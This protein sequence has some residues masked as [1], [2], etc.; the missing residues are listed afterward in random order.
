MKHS[1][2]EKGQALIL[3]VFAIFGLIGLTGLTIDGGNVYSDRRHA[4]NAA[5]AAVMAA[6]LAKVRGGD[7]EAAGLERAADN[8]YDNNGTSNT[9][10]VVSPPVSGTYVGNPDY[11]QVLIVSHVDTYFARVVGIPQMTN[12]VQA[13]SKTKLSEIGPLFD[14]QALVALKQTGTTFTTCGNPNVNVDASGI[15]VNSSSGCA[16]EV[17]G[18]VDLTVDT[19]YAIVNNTSPVCTNGNVNMVG[20]V[21]G[22][23]DQIEYPPRIDIAAPS[24]ECNGDGYL[25][26]NTYQPGNYNSITIN[27]GTINFAPGNYCFNGNV[28]INGGDVTANFVSFRLD[29]GEFLVRGNA[30]FT[31]DH[32]IVYGTGDSDGMHFNGTGDITATNTTFY[33]ETGDV[34]WNGN[35]DNT[36]TAPDTGPNANMLL[37]MPYGNTSGLTVNGNADSTIT[38]TILA[39]S[40]H[41]QVNGNS[42][43][44]ALYSQIVGYTVEACG[45]G[46]LNIHFDP[47]DNF[48]QLEPA[49]IELT[50]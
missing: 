46:D 2:Y 31:A 24:I 5:D 33:M 35:A 36:F 34:E 21:S 12:Q 37:Y 3:I 40:S 11:I 4:Q 39:V 16:M 17:I 48:E 22:G 27:H 50:E 25:D 38:G 18:N 1:R 13:V 44:N 41:V 23:A 42:S 29:S 20:P 30:T 8:D 19:G 15:F 45:N 9:V 10:Q 32:L 28:I 6:A 26:G 47:G 7:W 43:S 49:K 14:G